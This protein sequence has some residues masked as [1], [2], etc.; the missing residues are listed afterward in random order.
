MLVSIFDDKYE[1]TALSCAYYTDAV[2]SFHA[3]I[4]TLKHIYNF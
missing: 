1:N 3:L 2:T 4:A